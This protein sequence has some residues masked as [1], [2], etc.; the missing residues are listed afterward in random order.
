MVAESDTQ[1]HLCIDAANRIDRVA[2]LAHH[3]RDTPPCVHS[4]NTQDDVGGREWALNV[5]LA[6]QQSV[7]ALSES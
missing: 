1:Q 7:G 5:M 3:D 2:M 4:H 6:D